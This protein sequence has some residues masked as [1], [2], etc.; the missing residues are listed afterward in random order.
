[1]KSAIL[2]GAFA[3]IA[4]GITVGIQVTFINRGG[5]IIGAFRTG[6][7][8]NLGSGIF[9]LLLIAITLIWRIQEWRNMPNATVGTLILA[10]GLGVLIVIGAA[11][12]MSTV[13]VTAGL[14]SM[15]LRPIAGIH[16]R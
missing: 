16:N 8:T 6:V 5:N 15:I 9:S 2:F 12:A 14:S 11:Y 13:G 1:M 3:A 10:G 4:A 7:L